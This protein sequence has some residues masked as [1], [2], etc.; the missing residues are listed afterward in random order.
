MARTRVGENQGWPEPYIYTVYMR[1]FWQASY[2]IYGHRQ[3][4]Y[5]VLANP[6][7]DTMLVLLVL[8]PAP[9]RE[10]ERGIYIYRER[11]IER[12]REREG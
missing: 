9:E 4:I 5:T 3:C 12:E 2:Q 11:G 10:R 8:K 1:C 7:N 6:S